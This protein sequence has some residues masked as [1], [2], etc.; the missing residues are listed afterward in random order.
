MRLRVPMASLVILAVL[1]VACGGRDRNSDGPEPTD[2]VSA[3]VGIERRVDDGARRVDTTIDPGELEPPLPPQPTI[4]DMTIPCRPAT[5]ALWDGTGMPGLTA[6]SITIGTG[7]DRGGLYAAGFGRSIPDTV[8][9]L[10]DR[11]NALGGI[12]GRVVEVTEHDAAVVEVVD[13]VTAA[14]TSDFAL[15][16][17]GYLLDTISDPA[18]VECGLPAFPAWTTIRPAPESLTVM[19]LPSQP[20]QMS[21]DGLALAVLAAGES[22]QTVGMAVPATDGGRDAATRLEAAIGRSE[23]EVELI[24]WEYALSREPDWAAIV[25]EAA[26]ADV[27][28]LWV[29][30]SCESTLVPIMDAARA[31]GWQPAV[32]GGAGLYDPYCASVNSS[33]IDGVLVSMALHPIEDRESV[34]AVDEHV[35]LLRAAGVAPTADALLAASAFWLWATATSECDE[36][37]TRECVVSNADAID[38][39]TAGGLHPATDPAEG[40]GSGC[41]VIMSVIDGAFERLAPVRSGSMDCSPDLT[42]GSA[43]RPAVRTG[44]G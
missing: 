42:V 17:H 14:C 15:V 32:V 44:A 11:C 40:L 6:D 12:N 33:L 28:V 3:L 24:V 21:L 8:R 7:N 1:G 2:E 25:A 19:A 29:E 4:G 27:G 22:G 23:L 36:P 41:I 39:W 20:D 35:Q 43:D 18:R 9:V 37:L 31:R 38:T 30:G 16:G 5:E 26:A 13:R 10:A 34:D